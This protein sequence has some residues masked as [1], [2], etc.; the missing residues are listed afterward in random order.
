MPLFG[1]TPVPG[2]RDH[3][4]WAGSDHR[5][6]CLVAAPDARRARLYAANAFVNLAAPRTA[7]G[8]LPPS[9][10]R[11]P[12]LVAAAPADGSG[13]GAVADGTVLVPVDPDD[14]R[15]AYRPLQA[16]A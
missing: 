6:P 16:H 11:R 8:L 15:G 10:W 14:P 2:T 7:A 3:P 13:G 9:P 12:G 4:D 1:L 5:G